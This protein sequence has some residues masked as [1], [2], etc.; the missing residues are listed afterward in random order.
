MLRAANTFRGRVSRDDTTIDVK[1]LFSEI[2]TKL[3]RFGNEES[4]VFAEM[5]EAAAARQSVA[6]KYGRVA[7]RFTTVSFFLLCLFA[8]AS[9]LS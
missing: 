2:S 3:E 6:T 8:V 7:V 1:S 4:N 9:V 5:V